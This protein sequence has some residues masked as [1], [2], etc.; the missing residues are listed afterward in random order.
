MRSSIATSQ[1]YAGGHRLA[2]IKRTSQGTAVKKFLIFLVVIGAIGFVVQQYW[3][4]INYYPYA[5]R[6]CVKFA[7]ELG[8]PIA[9]PLAD[10]ADPKIFAASKW[11]KGRYIVVQLGQHVKGKSKSLFL[12]R[13]CVIGH[14]SMQ[15]PSMYEQREWEYR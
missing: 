7:E 15:M 8:A 6:D 13:L 9:G 5:E 3:D 14:G 11:I 2:P 4:V 10:P 1:N 12:S